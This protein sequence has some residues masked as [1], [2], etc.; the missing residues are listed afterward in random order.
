MLVELADVTRGILAL[1]VTHGFFFSL[2]FS[3]DS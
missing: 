2:F 1:G 3:S